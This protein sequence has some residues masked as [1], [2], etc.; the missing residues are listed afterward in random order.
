MR[1]KDQEREVRLVCGHMGK[2]LKII[3]SSRELPP[4]C[5]PSSLFAF[6]P[7]PCPVELALMNTLLLY[8]KG[9]SASWI[10]WEKLL[11]AA[12]LEWV[13]GEDFLSWKSSSM[14]YLSH[15]GLCGSLAGLESWAGWKWKLQL[16][17]F[18]RA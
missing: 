10:Q 15:P 8:F 16:S 13:V 7:S 14:V 12:A 1:N 6:K 3:T 5:A 17:K 9:D 18:Q 11:E 2:R 4:A